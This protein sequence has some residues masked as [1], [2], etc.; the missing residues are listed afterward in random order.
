MQNYAN[1][2]TASHGLATPECNNLP[3]GRPSS[4]LAFIKPKGYSASKYIQFTESSV[5]VRGETPTTAITKADM[6]HL[7]QNRG[8]AMQRY[9]QKKKNQRYNKHIRYESRKARADIRK[10]RHSATTMTASSAFGTKRYKKN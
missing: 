7:V 10:R 6:E 5:L 4:S 9:K 3:I 8:N 2:P 1:K